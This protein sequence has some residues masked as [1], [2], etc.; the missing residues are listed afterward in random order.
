MKISKKELKELIREEFR[1]LP[2]PMYG[3]E[4]DSP[5]DVL[6]ESELISLIDPETIEALNLIGRAVGKAGMEVV[7]PSAQV[8][9]LLQAFQAALKKLTGIDPPGNAEAAQRRSEEA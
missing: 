3:E 6:S 5:D 9:V 7:L 2:A 4:P 8:T 1:Q